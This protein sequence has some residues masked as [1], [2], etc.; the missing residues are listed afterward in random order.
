MMMYLPVLLFERSVNNIHIMFSGI[1]T[2]K[3]D[4]TTATAGITLQDAN[5]ILEKSKKGKL[6]IVNENGENEYL[7]T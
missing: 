5:R 3:T 4:L 6:P 2:A 7:P 1:M